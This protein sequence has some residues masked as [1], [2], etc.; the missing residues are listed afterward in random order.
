MP[1]SDNIHIAKLK[2]KAKSLHKSLHNGDSDAIAAAKKYFDEP[3]ISLQK[4]QL[5]VARQMGYASWSDVVRASKDF[6]VCSFCGKSQI[7]VRELIKDGNGVQICSECVM[8]CVGI[9]RDERFK[10]GEIIP[11]F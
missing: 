9:M 1:T 2:A 7:E 10:K 11:E 6:L 4:A 3:G 8:K 5:I